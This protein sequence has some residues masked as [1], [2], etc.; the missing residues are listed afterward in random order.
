VRP[1]EREELLAGYA[2]G[3]LSAPDATDVESLVATDSTAAEDLAR[4][5]EL[6]ELIALSVPMRRADPQLRQRV[7]AAARREARGRRL[8]WPRLRRV[9]P[10][11]A[12]LAIAVVAVGWGLSLRATVGELR[13]ESAALRVL[14][15]SAA[16]RLDAIDGGQPGAAGSRSLALQIATAL[17]DQQV[18]TAVQTD[19][20]VESTNLEPTLY[21]H[22]AGGR[23]LRSAA[24]DAAVIVARGL[25]QLPVGSVYRVWMDDGFS[26]LMASATFVPDGSGNVQ[27]VLRTRGSD[28]PVR[29]YIVASASGESQSVEGPVVLQATILRR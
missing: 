10:A 29:V 19:P 17:Q 8:R 2:L 9:L 4:Y 11:A 25:P 1:D 14:V 28:Q 26:Q 21:G 18:I 12:A 6:V 13:A 16:K 3:T 5:H 23:Y 24:A 22:G 27:V 7:L 20:E 15:Q